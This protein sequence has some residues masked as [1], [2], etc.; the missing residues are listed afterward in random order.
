MR[1]V[2]ALVLAA[3]SSHQAEMR[4]DWC[5]TD[6]ANVRWAGELAE[7]CD[8]GNFLACERADKECQR[9]GYGKLFCR[10]GAPAKT[11]T[12]LELRARLASGCEKGQSQDCFDHGVLLERAGEKADASFERACEYG[13]SEGCW[14]VADLTSAHASEAEN[15]GDWKEAAR[16]RRLGCYKNNLPN[17]CTALEDFRSRARSEALSCEAGSLDVCERAAAMLRATSQGPADD[18]RADALKRKI[19][20]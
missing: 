3:C 19:S 14:R 15:A 16:L 5:G 9:G 1:L 10:E 8:G 6:R 12:P 11:S 7:K 17:E 13:D 4:G 20:R 18:A 2:F